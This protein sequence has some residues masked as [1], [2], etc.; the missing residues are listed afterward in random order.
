MLKEFEDAVRGMKSGESKTF[1]L[2]FPADY[3]GKDVA[4][5]TADF[6]VTVKKIEAANLPEVN[7]DL[8]KSLGIAEGTVDGPARRHQEEP[9]ARSEVPPAGP[10]QAGRDGRAG[11]QG[12]ARPAQEPACSR[13][14]T[15]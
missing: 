13:K 6:M 14:S 11:R 9:R 1:P 8:A 12:R 5:K 2:A 15:A 10:Q 3:H 7:E 4:G